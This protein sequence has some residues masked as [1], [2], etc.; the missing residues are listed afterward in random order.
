MKRK[1][2]KYNK[3]FYQSDRMFVESTQLSFL[4][5]ESLEIVSLYVFAIFCI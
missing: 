1:E 2:S 3:I 4:V 5:K